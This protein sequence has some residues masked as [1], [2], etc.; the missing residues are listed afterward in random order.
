MSIFVVGTMVTKPEN[1]E[2][3]LQ[4]WRKFFS[5]MK[6]NTELFQEVKSFRVFSQMFGGGVNGFVELVEY[7]SLAD[8][9]KLHERLPKDSGYIKL[10][11]ERTV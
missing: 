6:K 7:E 3:L 4:L 5:F 8:Y 9:E 11:Q 2:A 1:R 10:I